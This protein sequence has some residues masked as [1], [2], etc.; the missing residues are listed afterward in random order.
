LSDQ[1]L[2]DLPATELRRLIGRKAISPVE[3]LGSCLERIEAVNPTLNAMTAMCVE[4]AR[5]EAEA[6]EAA[7]RA[8]DALGP[9]HG[10]PIGIK[11]L[12]LT[13]GLRTTFGSPLFA[14]HVPDAD[15]RTV[16]AV[17]RAGGIVLGKTNVPEWGAGAN[18]RNPV[19]GATGNPF[20]PSRTCGGSSGGSAV[21]LATSMVP[22]ATG[23]DT[24]GSLRTPASF[25]G[26]V[27]FRPTPGLVPSERRGLGWT[28]ISVLGPMGRDVADTCLLLSAMVGD[29]SRDP[30]AAPVDAAGFAG[31]PEVDLSSLRVAISE[32]LG[33]AP[34]ARE[35]RTVFRERVARIAGLFHSCESADPEMAD[36]DD[37]FEVIR[38][39]NF[40]AQH[41]R[42]HAE[43]PD[44]LGPN[45]VA[46]L[47]QAMGYDLADFARAHANQTRIY[48]AFQGFFAERDIL[49]CPAAAVSPFPWEQLYVEAIDG[50]PLRTYFHWLALS[51]GL[52]LTGHPVCV[53]PCGSDRLGLPFG[54]QICGPHRSDRF[55]LG[56]AQALEQSLARNAATARPISTSFSRA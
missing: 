10:L 49:I 11:D 29:D 23:S 7:V 52:T 45:I 33:F 36:A 3:L 42:R 25:C 50:E 4:R 19:Y 26:V 44:M 48:R 46:N 5:A 41:G 32:D 12:Q 24:G 9:L 6:A 1:P 47:E 34:V 56:V 15:E 37:A 28:P 2:C 55:V 18:T 31:P 27:G 16:A 54:I 39:A 35:I 30:F 20:D 38:G 8:G 17:R 51:Y 14:D 40:L 43:T 13:E 22:L 21:A 53:I